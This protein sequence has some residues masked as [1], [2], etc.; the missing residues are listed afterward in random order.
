MSK[1]LCV[2]VLL[3]YAV[4]FLAGSM[5]LGTR[6]LFESNGRFDGVVIR[7][8]ATGLLEVI[9]G[10]L[11][12]DQLLVVKNPVNPVAVSFSRK[13]TECTFCRTL[14]GMDDP[15]SID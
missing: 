5:D 6:E 2:N 1:S 12:G 4:S 9:D 8:V 14:F 3:D 11:Q 10:C 15:V 13:S 7:R